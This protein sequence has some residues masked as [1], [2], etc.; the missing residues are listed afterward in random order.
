[1]DALQ[2]KGRPGSTPNLRIVATISTAEQGARR[3]GGCTSHWPLWRASP[4]EIAKVLVVDPLLQLHW[5]SS[6]TLVFLSA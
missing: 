2:S 4:S 1:M 6:A 5:W 3:L